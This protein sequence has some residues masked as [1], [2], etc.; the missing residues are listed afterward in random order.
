MTGKVVLTI[1]LTAED[2]KRI[3]E[4]ALRRG[5]STV[6]DYLLALVE[7]DADELT[8]AEDVDIRA[9]L[10]EGLRQALHGETVPLESLWDDDDE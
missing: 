10:K 7:A 8:E 3:E 5:Y 6:G 4:L 9:E 1:D 2:R